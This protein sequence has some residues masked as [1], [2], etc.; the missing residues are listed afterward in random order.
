MPCSCHSRG[1]TLDRNDEPGWAKPRLVGY[2]GQ[3][4]TPERVVRAAIVVVRIH[5][6]LL[7]WYVISKSTEI[8][9]NRRIGKCAV[10]EAY[11]DIC[12]SFHKGS[13]YGDPGV[14]DITSNSWP[15]GPQPPDRTKTFDTALRQ[16]QGD[17]MCC[18][19][20]ATAYNF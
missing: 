11:I 13:C 18:K 17:A 16:Q 3:R 12:R 7:I 15:S 6:T 1:Q 14:F 9:T 20:L 19:F 8:N 10:H 4:G 5:S 2:E